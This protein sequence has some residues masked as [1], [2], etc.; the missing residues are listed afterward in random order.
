VYSC[1]RLWEE[2]RARR[3][4]RGVVGCRRGENDVEVISEGRAGEGGSVRW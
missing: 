1:G 3:R 2:A 4:S